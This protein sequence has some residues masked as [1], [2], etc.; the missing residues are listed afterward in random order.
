MLMLD[1]SSRRAA[2][3]V[4]SC[5]AWSGIL[6]STSWHRAVHVMGSCGARPGIVWGMG[7]PTAE[8]PDGDDR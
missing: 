6:R 8:S 4:A 7:E 3:V 5:G 1:M 2:S